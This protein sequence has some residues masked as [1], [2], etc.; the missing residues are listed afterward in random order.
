L[1]DKFANEGKSKWR[2][3][4]SNITY[5]AMV[6]AMDQAVGKVIKGLKDQGLYEN[7]IIVFFSDNGGLSTA[8]GHPTT[9]LPLRAG[10]GWLY[11][12]GIREPLIARW[13]GVT[14]AGADN[15]TRVTSPDFFPTLV[16]AAGVS[17]EKAPDRDG[18]SFLSALKGQAVDDTRPLFW[19]YPHY[20][21]QGGAPG[22]AMLEGNW[23]LIEW[24]D[25]GR[26][27]LFDLGKDESEKTNLAA[28]EPTRVQAMQTRLHAW[29]KEVG[30]QPS[31][32]NPAYDPA[33]P[34]GRR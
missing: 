27:E 4:Q 17:V 7:T 32:P 21:N 1:S 23:K 29:Q 19:H 24:L 22:A 13:P 25:D 31:T 11:E 10:K 8:E 9:N 12:G 2:I 28:T 30:A 26:V 6:D 14:P 20:G 34:N 15:A 5:A 18:R 33:K 3:E 16:E